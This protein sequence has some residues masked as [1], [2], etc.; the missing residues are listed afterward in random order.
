MFYKTIISESEPVDMGDAKSGHPGP[1]T[2]S[3]RGKAREKISEYLGSY[4]IAE[5]E[6][7]G[8]PVYKQHVRCAYMFSTKGGAWDVGFISSHSFKSFMRSTTSATCPTLCQQW[9]YSANIMGGAPW[10]DGDITVRYK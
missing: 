8:R 1:F 9:Q 5:K 2:L 4:T 3:A 7:Y 10:K 6:R